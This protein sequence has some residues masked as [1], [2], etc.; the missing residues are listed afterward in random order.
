MCGRRKE[1][2]GGWNIKHDQLPFLGTRRDVVDATTLSLSIPMPGHHLVRL[3][4]LLMR[5]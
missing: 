2:S 4:S 1:R 3:L 5:G